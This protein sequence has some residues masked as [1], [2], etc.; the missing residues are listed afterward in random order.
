MPSVADCVVTQAMSSLEE[1]DVPP[2]LQNRIDQHQQHLT[3]LASAL[4]A[5]GQN[6]DDV[7]QT[8]EDVLDSFKEELIKT[9]RSLIEG[10]HA[11]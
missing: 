2:I 9:I 7:R 3:S 4:L 8:I 5:G 6:S 10:Q 1:F 11:A